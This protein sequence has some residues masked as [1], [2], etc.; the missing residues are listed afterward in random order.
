MRTV[1][2]ADPFSQSSVKFADAFSQGCRGR[3]VTIN[4]TSLDPMAVWKSLQAGSVAAFFT[5]GLYPILK[6]AQSEGRTWF[7]GDHAYFGRKEFFRVTRSGYQFQGGSSGDPSRFHFF[8]RTVEPWQRRAEGR[9]LVCPNSPVHFALHGLDRSVWIDEVCRTLRQYTSRQIDIREKPKTRYL[10]RSGAE[11]EPTM[12][13]QINEALSD[14]WAVV[15]YSS[16]VAIDAL[17]AGVPAFVLAPFSAAAS[18][19]RSDLSQIE[20]PL[21]P[22]D[23]LSFLSSWA[24]NQWTLREIKTGV[25]WKRLGRGAD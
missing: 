5:P 23:R 11:L 18:M 24:A 3:V 21:Y 9:V 8:G 19:C 1:C 15:T 14:C 25:T 4:S 2:Y 12:T 7:Y 17:I 20:D 13:T 22:N 16:A 10:R 6:A